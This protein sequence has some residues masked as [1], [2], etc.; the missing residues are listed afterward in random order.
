VNFDQTDEFAKDVKQ[1]S[2]KWRTLASDIEYVKPRLAK[3]Y[4]GQD[5]QA[6]SD[7]RSSFF[8]GKRATILHMLQ[9]G[10]EIVKMRL[11]VAM[12]GNSDKARLIFVAI[13][14]SNTITF[15]ELYA[16]NEKERENMAR[17]RRYMK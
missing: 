3:L 14:Q 1:L 13:K 5:P 9:N 7:L 6:L 10:N 8:N 12:L 16:K 2:K 4:I 17:I 15:I 11:D